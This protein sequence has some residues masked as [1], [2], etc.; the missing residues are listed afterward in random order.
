M[1]IP[2]ILEKIQRLQSDNG[3]FP[4]QEGGELR[5]DATAWAVMAVS[6][7]EESSTDSCARARAFLKANQIDDGRITLSPHH[8]DVIWPT[9]LAIFA[10]EG[11][12]E[13]HSEQLRAVEFLLGFTGRHFPKQDDSVAGHDPSIRGWPW[14]TNTHSWVIPT[15]MAIG[16]LKIR[17]LRTHERVLEAERMLLDRQ[18]PHG[19]WNYGNT[20][21][22][23]KELHPLP[24]FT[25]IALQALADQT[26][27]ARI[28]KSL[29]YLLEIFPHLH[30]PISLGWAILGLGAWGLRPSNVHERIAECLR[31]QKRYGSYSVSSLALLLC[32]IKAH[33]D[34]YSIFSDNG[35]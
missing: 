2:S 30:T 15:S 20:L 25:G 23:G 13:F 6:A 28:Q 7:L 9:S 8:S 29:D 33:P 24:E 31:L 19:G 35:Q 21:A 12:G 18:L 14:M 4:N 11:D 26:D 16:A 1:F 27:K 3:G 32:A 22:F 5:P 10:W 34:F 17:G